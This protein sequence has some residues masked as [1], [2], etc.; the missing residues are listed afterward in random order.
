MLGASQEL[1]NPKIEIRVPYSVVLI[2]I[3][4][5]RGGRSSFCV[6]NHPNEVTV[7]CL[8]ECKSL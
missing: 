3:I 5:G 8:I 2:I 1:P 4:S 6:I 7:I